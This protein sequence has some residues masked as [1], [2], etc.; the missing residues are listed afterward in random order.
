MLATSFWTQ[1]PFLKLGTLR[2]HVVIV[3]LQT[4]LLDPTPDI[5]V[6]FRRRKQVVGIVPYVRLKP[7]LSVTFPG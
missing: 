2:E 1:S 4:L 7:T 6:L 5:F 3:S